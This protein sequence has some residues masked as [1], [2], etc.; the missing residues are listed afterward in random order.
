MPK[1]EPLLIVSALPSVMFVRAAHSKPAIP[2]AMLMTKAV[3]TGD[4]SAGSWVSA[5][6]RSAPCS[7]PRDMPYQLSSADPMLTDRSRV[8]HSGRNVPALAVT[9]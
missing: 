4:F 8:S 1:S 7:V 6:G 9:R 5:K 3:P 2:S